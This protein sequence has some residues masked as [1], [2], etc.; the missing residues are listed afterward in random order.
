MPLKDPIKFTLLI[1][2]KD[3]EKDIH[4]AAESSIAQT[5]PYKEIIFVDDSTDKTKTIIQQYID[6]GLSLLMARERVV[7]KRVI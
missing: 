2:C 6:R 1:A 3:E 7:V 5:Y 4:L